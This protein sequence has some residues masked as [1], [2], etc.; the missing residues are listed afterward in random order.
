MVTEPGTYYY[1]LLRS[2][3]DFTSSPKELETND[4]G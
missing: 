1:L 2:K 3:N 4:T